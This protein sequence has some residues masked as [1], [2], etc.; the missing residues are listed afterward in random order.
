MEA[1]RFDVA[2]DIDPAFDAAFRSA[3]ASGVEAYAY[4]CRITSGEI[5]IA[6]AVEIVT[7]RAGSALPHAARSSALRGRRIS[8]A[9]PP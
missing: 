3:L 2:R 7:P 9:E 4:A 6:R 8:P 5:G 1:E